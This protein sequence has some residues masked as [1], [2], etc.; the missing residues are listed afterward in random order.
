MES[1]INNINFI[2][3]K[4]GSDET[5]IMYTRRDNIEIMFGDNN[6]DITE[7]LFESLLQK[8]EKKITE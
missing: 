5:H 4:P 8:Y 6:D 3:L 7:Q 2:S 1:T